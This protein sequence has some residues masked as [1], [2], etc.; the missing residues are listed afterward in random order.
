MRFIKGVAI[1]F[2]NRIFIVFVSAVSSIII[3]RYLGPAGKGI[4]SVL[5]T[6]VGVGF[7]FGNL[8]FHVLHSP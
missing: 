6:V 1:T 2:T 5:W 4:F 8:G 3:A 7:Q